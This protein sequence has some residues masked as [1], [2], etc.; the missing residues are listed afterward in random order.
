MALDAA[1]SVYRLH[2][3]SQAQED[4]LNADRVEDERITLWKPTWIPVV[5]HSAND[6]SSG[7]FLD[8]ATGYLGR[9]TRYH[10]R[11][12]EQ[13]DTLVTYLE[14]TADMLE[15]PALATRDTPGLVGDALVWRSRLDAAQK[16]RWRPLAD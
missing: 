7:M 13:L 14:E 2:M 1:A 4:V 11:L 9:W 6:S 16:D 10:A 8:A 5:A 15:A 3:G 12:G